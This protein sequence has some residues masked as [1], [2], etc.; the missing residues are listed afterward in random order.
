MIKISLQAA[1]TNAG[2]TQEQVA[3]KLGVAIS[4][5]KNWEK[6]IT[7]PKINQAYDLCDLYGVPIDYIKFPA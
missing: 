3:D 1:R 7:T 2:L 6:G 4:T 5:V